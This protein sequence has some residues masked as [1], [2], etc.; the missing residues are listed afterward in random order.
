MADSECPGRATKSSESQVVAARSQN[1]EQGYRG[2]A[3][4]WVQ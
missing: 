1:Q 3:K 2:L 4:T